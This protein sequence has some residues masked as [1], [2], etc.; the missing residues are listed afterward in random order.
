MNRRDALK[1]LGLGAVAPLDVL[2][3]LGRVPA[4]NSYGF[5]AAGEAL[6]PVVIRATETSSSLCEA[7]VTR[8]EYRYASM[9][10]SPARTWTREDSGWTGVISSRD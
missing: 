6:I 2:D 7:K 10:S 4:A 3:K 8:I 5:G 1:L 9:D